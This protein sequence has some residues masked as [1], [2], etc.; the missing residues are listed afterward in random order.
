MSK[1]TESCTFLHHLNGENVNCV[2][3]EI[4]INYVAIDD[5][6]RVLCHD[7]QHY[8]GEKL[9]MLLFELLFSFIHFIYPSIHSWADSIVPNKPT[10]IPFAF[11]NFQM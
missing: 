1:H 9:S 6:K 5:V 7:A 4:A 10:K 3:V 2:L 11:G 8:E